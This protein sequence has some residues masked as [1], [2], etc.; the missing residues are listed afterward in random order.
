MQTSHYPPEIEAKRAEY[1]RLGE[2]PAIIAEIDASASRA[3]EQVGGD[4][5]DK[6]ALH[7]GWADHIIALSVD[8]NL[9]HPETLRR[10]YAEF[11]LFI[12]ERNA[13]ED[14]ANQEESKKRPAIAKTKSA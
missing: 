11:R 13:R 5:S 1:A 9:H 2:S 4:S 6:D 12:D 3:L 14:A 10:F 7:D 8:L